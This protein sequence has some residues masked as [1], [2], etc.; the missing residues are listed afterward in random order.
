MKNIP[1][2]ECGHTMAKNGRRRIGR[3]WYQKWLCLQCGRSKN[4]T[5]E[6][7][8]LKKWKCPRHGFTL[9]RVEGYPGALVCPMSASRC[10]DIF[11]E[12][13]GH[14]CYSTGTQWID[15]KTG[16]TKQPEA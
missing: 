15:V 5:I 14:L 8:K 11:T 1:C 12:I 10:P 4:T 6:E 9:N 16:E 2:P 3:P 13:D 7:G